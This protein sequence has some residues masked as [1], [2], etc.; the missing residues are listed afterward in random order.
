MSGHTTRQ[1]LRIVG[2]HCSSCAMAIDMA[3][4]DLHS[5]AEARTNY[6]RASTE[7]VFD[8]QRVDLGAL[9]EAVREAG[10]TAVAAAQ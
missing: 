5:V 10:Y 4:E 2:M 7:V 3:L 6:A 8:P 1:T 9:V